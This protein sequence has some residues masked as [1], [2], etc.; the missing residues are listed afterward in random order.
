MSGPLVVERM[1]VG[2]LH[3]QEDEEFVETPGSLIGAE[4]LRVTIYSCVLV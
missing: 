4:N 2:V 1:N 3:I